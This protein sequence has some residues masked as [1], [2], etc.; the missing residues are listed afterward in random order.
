MSQIGASELQTEQQ[1]P[2]ASDELQQSTQS[3]TPEAVALLEVICGVFKKLAASA[4]EAYL[5]SEVKTLKSH[6]QKTAITEHS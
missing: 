1:V 4:T 5:P 3:H 2:L 6:L